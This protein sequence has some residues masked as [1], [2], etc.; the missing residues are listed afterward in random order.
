MIL[1]TFSPSQ[2]RLCLQELTNKTRLPKTTVLRLLKT[3]ISLNY[4]QFNVTT[5]QYYLGSEAMSLGFT[6]LWSMDLREAALPYLEEL[7]AATQQNVGLSIL[8]GIDAVYIER[9]KKIPLLGI[10]LHVGSRLKVYRSA[11]GRAILA[12][13][14]EDKF[15]AVLDKILA[16]EDTV[17]IVG[18][19]GK[20][21]SSMLQEVRKQGWA[22][23][24]HELFPGMLAIAAPIFNATGTVEG[25]INMPLIGGVVSKEDII[26]KYVPMLVDTAKRISSARGCQEVT[27]CSD[28]NALPLQRTAR[29]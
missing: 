14:E 9:I 22:L 12:Y 8:D 20:I 4:I 27:A 11:M 28:W 19:S 25:A 23:S 21:L 26:R 29:N 7:S 5:K 15:N 3:L 16:E 6:V 24:E 17:K 10:D 18:R 13:L 2:P 1:K